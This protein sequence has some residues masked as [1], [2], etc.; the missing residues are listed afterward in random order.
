MN[1]SVSSS[2]FSLSTGGL[3]HR[4]ML[5]VR[6]VEANRDHPGRRIAV[7]VGI[8][9]L[10]LLILT[11]IDNTLVGAGIKLTFLHDPVP[12]VRYLNLHPDFQRWIKG[13]LPGC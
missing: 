9:W 3:F 6:L 7:F 10:P 5:L 8:T 4:L 11:V 1:D 13:L 2:S 12:H